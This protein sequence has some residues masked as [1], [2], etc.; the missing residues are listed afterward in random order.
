MLSGR[1]IPLVVDPVLAAKNGT[2]LLATDALDAAMEHLFP[3]ATLI[4]PNLDEASSIVGRTIETISDMQEASLEMRDRFGCGA[5]LVKGG[6]LAGNDLVDLLCDADGFA[7]FSAPRIHTI[8]TRGTG[9]TFSAAITAHLG[10][11]LPLRDAVAKSRA[12][13]QKAIESAPACGHGRGGL[14]HF[15]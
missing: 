15:A 2:A 1:K 13:L 9:C 5:I 11:G 12:W 14:D 3:L 4:T 6:H 10:Y 8:H 7:Q